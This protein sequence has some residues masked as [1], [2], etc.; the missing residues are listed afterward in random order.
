MIGNVGEFYK[1]LKV[2]FGAP[3]LPSSA[4]PD[5]EARA[6]VEERQRLAAERLENEQIFLR[7]FKTDFGGFSERVY[8]LAAQKLRTDPSAK[9]SF[10]VNGAILAACQEVQR[11]LAM[12][13]AKPAAT[14]DRNPEWSPKR[15]ELANRM[16]HSDL[17]RQAAEEGWIVS[18]HDFCRE[19][20]RLPNRFEAEKVRSAALARKAERERRELEFGG[21]PKLIQVIAK[22]ME[23]KRARLSAL[24]NE[25]KPEAFES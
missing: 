18:L 6:D 19:Q 3:R 5:E 17:G 10:P 11:E 16:M 22:A 1:T 21:N 15:I 24:A 14:A 2:H 13:G 20:A 12:D 4:T 8:T 7:D 23:A 25:A 9:K